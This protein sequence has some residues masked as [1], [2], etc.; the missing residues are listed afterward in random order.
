MG[1]N[2]FVEIKKNLLEYCCC[3][4]IICKLFFWWFI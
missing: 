1:L 4:I 3:C 2:L